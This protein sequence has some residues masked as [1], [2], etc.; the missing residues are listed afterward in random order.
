MTLDE[1]LGYLD[2]AR[3][4]GRSNYTAKCPGPLHEKGDRNPSLSITDSDDRILLHC[5]AGCT[6]YDITEALGLKLSDL[7]YGG[8]RRPKRNMF[9]ASELLTLL[10]N[11][12]LVI[13]IAAENLAALRPLSENDLERV[14]SASDRI[15]KLTGSYT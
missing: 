15:R 5:H 8:R 10:R 2:S 11:E 4:S 14:R 1:F 3:S 7:F 12:T 9:T 13:A 6:A